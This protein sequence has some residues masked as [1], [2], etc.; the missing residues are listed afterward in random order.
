MNFEKKYLKYKNKYLKLKNQYGGSAKLNIYILDSNGNISEEP[1]IVDNIERHT[2]LN[3]ILNNDYKN[4]KAFTYHKNNISEGT[5]LNKNM[6][7]RDLNIYFENSPVDILLVHPDNATPERFPLLN[8]GYN[9]NNSKGKLNI[10]IEDYEENIIGPFSLNVK[11]NTTLN[12]LMK[13]NTT[14]NNLIKKFINN[15]N[16]NNNNNNNNLQLENFLAFTYNKNNISEGTPLN[17]NM[18]VENLNIYFENS[19]SDILLVHLDLATPERFPLLNYG[20]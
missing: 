8:Y 2:T 7:V 9:L 13:K 6:S 10:Y 12:N 20:Y 19:P 17:K 15:N 16:I 4:F 11:K 1:Y 14:L 18:S 3:E 5:P